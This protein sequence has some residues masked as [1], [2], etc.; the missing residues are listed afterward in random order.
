MGAGFQPE[1]EE[2]ITT[3]PPPRFAEVGQG[4]AGGA[5]RVK[6]VEVEGRGPVLVAGGFEGAPGSPAD[7]V[8]EDV[9]PSQG[10]GRGGDEALAFPGP[11]DV[12]GDAE[13]LCPEGIQ[14]R[15]HLLEAVA[16]PAADA[17]LAAFAG[18]AEGDG[19][20]DAAA[21]AGNEG[22]FTGQSEIHEFTFPSSCSI[23]LP[24]TES[25]PAWSIARTVRF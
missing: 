15:Q 24:L 4:G 19:A 17:E 12:R 2:M 9:G 11:D 23:T 22:G 7:V 20:A 25:A 6:Q 18:E 8:D 3:L 5:H 10:L 1:I 14:L 21:A 16:A 13:R